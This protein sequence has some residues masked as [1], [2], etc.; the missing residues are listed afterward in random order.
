MSAAIKETEA[1]VYPTLLAYV[2]D[3]TG[4]ERPSLPPGGDL[5]PKDNDHMTYLAMCVRRKKTLAEQ[6]DM[7]RRQAL[8][9]ESFAPGDPCI[10]RMLNWHRE[11]LGAL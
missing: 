10:E 3:P 6:I 4:P 8:L 7:V 11:L 1:F 5:G 9:L 2:S